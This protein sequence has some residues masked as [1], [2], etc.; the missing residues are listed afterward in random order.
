MIWPPLRS[1]TWWDGSCACSALLDGS[2]IFRRDRQGGRGGGVAQYGI[3]GV[4]CMELTAGNGTVES[5]WIR[6][7]GRTNNADAI[8]GVHYRPPGQDT[9]EL[10]FEELRDSSKSTALVLM[11]EFN[12][13]TS[14]TWYRPGQNIPKDLDDSFME[15][16]WKD[17]LLDL[18]LVNR[19]DLV[20]KWRSV[21][22]LATVT[23]KQLN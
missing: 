13:G 16:A 17:A 1:E 2:R 11:G 6:I 3:E 21:A 22:I 15:H 14:H 18:L 9:D 5:L 4:E 12:L 8:T 7:K 20:S 10:F 19:V 23:M